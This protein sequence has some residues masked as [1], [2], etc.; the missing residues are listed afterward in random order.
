[1]AATRSTSRL[2]AKTAEDREILELIDPV[3]DSIG[4]SIVR[5]R[6]MGGTLR[7][8]L[9]VMAERPADNDIDVERMRPPEP[10]HV[11][12]IWTPPIRSPANICWKCR[13]PASTGR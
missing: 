7:R 3:A 9:Q 4:L 10:R 12:G 1:M 5:V 13:R 2:R 11:R 6:L 8:R